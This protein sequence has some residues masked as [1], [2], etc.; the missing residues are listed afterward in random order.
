MKPIKS[1]F[2][3]LFGIFMLPMIASSCAMEGDPL[4]GRN[5]K[6]FLSGNKVA[7]EGNWVYYGLENN[8][9]DVTSYAVSLT[10][11]AKNG[12]GAISIPSTYNALPVTGIW[13]GAFRGSNATSITIPD[14]ITV[15]D[16]EA[17]MYSRVTEIAIPSSVS[18][19]GEGAF[20]SCPN[21]TNVRINNS[22]ETGSGYANVCSATGGEESEDILYSNLQTIPAFCFF[23]CSKLVEL[24]LPASIKEVSYE[25]FRGCARMKSMLSFKNLDIIRARAFEGCVALTKVYIP[26]SFFESSANTIEPL[27]FNYCSS[28]LHFIFACEA[29]TATTW[30]SNHPNW[31]WYNELGSPATYSYVYNSTSTSN[32]ETTQA[33]TTYTND[34]TYNTEFNSDTNE[35]EVTITSYVGTT[36]DENN[37]NITFITVPNELGGYPVRKIETTAFNSI[38]RFIKRIFLPTTLQRIEVS[39]FNADYKELLVVDSNESCQET[40]NPINPRIDLSDLTDLEEIRD[41]AFCN[42][43]KA[44]SIRIIHLP[45]HLK[46]VGKEAFSKR[47]QSDTNPRLR[48]VKEFEWDYN[49]AEAQLEFIGTDC[50]FKMGL[51]DEKKINGSSCDFGGQNL[52]HDKKW[53]TQYIHENHIDADGNVNYT[54]STII[55]PKTFK[56]F[57]YPNAATAALYDGTYDKGAAHTF[58][59]CPLLGNVIF[60][61]GEGSNDLFLPI[62]TFAFNES[63]RNVVFEERPGKTIT[64]LTDDGKYSEVCIGCSA[65]RFHNDFRGDPGLQTLVLPNQ[66]TVL[67]I[68]RLAFQGNSRGVIYMSGSASNSTFMRSSTVTDLDAFNSNPIPN[69]AISYA[70]GWRSIG[71]ESWFNYGDKKAYLG[72]CFAESETTKSDQYLNSYLL[73]QSMPVYENIHYKQTFIV[74]NGTE[75]VEVTAEVGSDNTKEFVVKD[76]CAFVT[77]TSTGKATMT[78]YLYDRWD[79]TFTGTAR[80]PA[81][82]KGYDGTTYTV[83]K[84]GESAFTA[85]FSDGID[86]ASK[87]DY[88]DLTTVL[89]P[90]AI[91][92]IGDYAFL[93]AYGVE[94]I[95]GYTPDANDDPTGDALN[96]NY[97]MPTSLIWIGKNGLS[98]CNVK[99][100]LGLRNDVRFYE[101][102]TT[103]ND[104]DMTSVF[105]NNLSLRVISFLSVKNYF[106]TTYISESGE[107]YTSALYANIS[108]VSI[109]TNGGRLLLILNRDNADVNKPS[110]DYTYTDGV[111]TFDLGYHS[112]SANRKFLYGATRMGYWIKKLKI[113]SKTPSNQAFFSAVCNRRI[114]NEVMTV[115]DSYIYLFEPIRDYRDNVCD[116]TAAEGNIFSLQAYAFAGCEQFD[117][118]YLN[119]NE[120][121]TLPNGVFSGAENITYVTPG[122][123]GDGDNYIGERLVDPTVLDLSNTKYAGIGSETFRDNEIFD[124]VRIPNNV[125][126]FTIG[127]G[128]FRD[129]DTLTTLDLR[130]AKQ[131]C[132]INI[133]DSA[134]KNSGLTTIYWPTKSGCTVNITGGFRECPSLTNLSFSST[135]TTNIGEYAFYSCSGL[136]RIDFTGLVGEGISGY[137]VADGKASIGNYAFQN[138]KNLYNNDG[139]TLIIPE[140]VVA[141]GKQ[142]FKSSG[143]KSVEF[144]AKTMQFSNESFDNCT[145]MSRVYFSYNGAD[146]NESNWDLVSD[147]N[148]QNDQFNTFS[149]CG[150]NLTTIILPPAFDL[151]NAAKHSI[152]W[153]SK[154]VLFYIRRT[155][156]STDREPETDW[157][158]R[159]G[160]DAGPAQCHFQVSTIADVLNSSYTDTTYT[161]AIAD[162]VISQDDFYWYLQ[163]GDAVRLGQIDKTEMEGD[164]V[165]SVYFILNG[166]GTGKL[167]GG[168]GTLYPVGRTFSA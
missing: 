60:K 32:V 76:K 108:G 117:T 137:D 98:F 89:M 86:Q 130:T 31:G 34:W 64:F 17:F 132:T 139:D 52:N 87:E 38:K 166:V 47:N 3:L 20:Y 161:T 15:I 6:H 61:G 46:M 152:V 144:K 104:K 77:G 10:D 126:S 45:Y 11:S 42:I 67:C 110:A 37:E 21:L 88:K 74:N 24:S 112:H 49:E 14:S 75:N 35:S 153:Q 9:G 5:V 121:G 159:E 103:G 142:S 63:L 147:I 44:S 105:S 165:Y 168:D 56:G 145:S 19:I 39:M 78:N 109:N 162:Y 28:S 124:T 167:H 96:A 54:P 156:R 120:G 1:L 148:I 131:G 157:R 115:T 53:E 41:F 94:E 129:C 141:I 83:N 118:I 135:V 7:T 68:Q 57:G 69:K 99:K 95:T 25:A 70:T 150:D 128:A 59:G 143:I 146:A 93:R 58:A 71:D 158:L 113:A 30:I 123:N 13:E 134:F 149:D 65:G 62:Q 55:F 66:Q 40:E 101:N 164:G 91:T 163:N 18:L 127:S 122:P 29:A 160:T 92:E 8:N 138:C 22:N 48:H 4:A 102:V 36:V 80:V 16:Y 23:K 155:I 81:T 125:S 90:N 43:P 12:T 133:N 136:T 97:T 100:I 140:N 116:L 26:N 85:C 111:G 151:Y 82:V 2:A 79:S 107:T 50:F 73:D 72:Y 27:A 154:K 33:S 106:T 84:I 51:W 114:V 119:Q